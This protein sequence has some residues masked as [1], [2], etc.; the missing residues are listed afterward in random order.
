MFKLCLLESNV[1]WPGC[2]WDT[3]HILLV[4]NSKIFTHTLTSSHVFAPCTSLIRDFLIRLYGTSWKLVTETETSFHR[5]LVSTLISSPNHRGI[6][7]TFAENTASSASHRSITQENSSQSSSE[8]LNIV[9]V[10]NGILDDFRNKWFG[11]SWTIAR[12]TSTLRFIADQEEPE[13]EGVLTQYLTAIK[14]IEQLSSEVAQH[15]LHASNGL[16]GQPVP[17]VSPDR[18]TPFV[19]SIVLE[20]LE[21]QGQEASISRNDKDIDG[22]DDELQQMN[23]NFQEGYALVQPGIHS[24]TIHKSKLY[25][26]S[27][28]ICPRLYYSQKLDHRHPQC[29]QWIPSCWM[30]K[31]HQ[32]K[33][34]QSW[35]CP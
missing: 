29:S 22:E 4:L 3:H 7:S 13:K 5:I 23:L 30:G 33:A 21:K 9:R 26:N 17:D 35:Q 10:L 12:L 18:Q 1:I 24:L 6:V 34:C 8:S 19:R 32:G 28:Q 20:Q 15:G 25:R 2:S 11:K 31:H 27:S 14:S 16:R